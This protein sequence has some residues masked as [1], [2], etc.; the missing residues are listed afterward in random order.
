M[1]RSLDWSSEEREEKKSF[2]NIISRGKSMPISVSIRSCC[3]HVKNT[4]KAIN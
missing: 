3:T 2:M 4:K 1:S